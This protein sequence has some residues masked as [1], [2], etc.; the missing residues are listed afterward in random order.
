MTTPTP[1]PIPDPHGWCDAGFTVACSADGKGGCT[2][3]LCEGFPPAH[4]STFND[5]TPSGV[6]GDL[7]PHQVW[8][9][10]LASAGLTVL[11]LLAVLTLALMV[12]RRLPSP[13]A[14]P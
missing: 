14:R 4:E 1:T 11:V 2:P 13:G 3:S 9:F 10:D 6:L 5:F 12:R 7:A 8:H